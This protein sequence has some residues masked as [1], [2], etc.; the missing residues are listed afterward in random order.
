MLD[1]ATKA[2]GAQSRTAAVHTALK[3]VVALHRF[4]RLM[5]RYAGKLE[6][7]GCAA[8]ISGRSKLRY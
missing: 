6:F 1:E 3:E 4:K 2:L 8:K 7:A 5:K